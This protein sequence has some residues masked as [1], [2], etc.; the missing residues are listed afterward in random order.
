MT[1]LVVMA[2]IIF[3]GALGIIGIDIYLAATQGFE[4]TLSYWVL[5]NSIKYPIIPALV[6]LIIG[7]LIGHFWWDQ[8]L[9]VTVPCPVSD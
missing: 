9:N 5:V 3:A 4:A 2:I 8:V 1:G 7:L 6:C